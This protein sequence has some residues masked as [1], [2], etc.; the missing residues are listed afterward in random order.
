MNHHEGHVMAAAS[1]NAVL[2]HLYRLAGTEPARDLPDAELLRRFVATR[3]EAAFTLLV[4]RHGAMVLG[5]CRRI[6]EDLH[7]AEDAFQATFVVLARRAA[8]L[9]LRGS[10]ASWLYGVALRV[11]VSARGRSTT[12]RRYERQAVAMKGRDTV[13]EVEWD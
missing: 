4:Q 2:R 7:S 8:S 13:D 9:R 11:A 10:L 3:E 12:R 5:A 1:L 6:L